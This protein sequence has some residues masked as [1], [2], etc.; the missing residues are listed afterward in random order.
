MEEIKNTQGPSP[1]VGIALI[2]VVLVVVAV[3]FGSK[4]NFDKTPIK[5]LQNVQLVL[6]RKTSDELKSSDDDQDNLPLWLE[7]FY[8]SDPNNADTDGDGTSDGDEVAVK[9]DPTVAGPD[10]PLLTF[11]DNLETSI[12]VSDFKPGTLTESVSVDLFQKY[13]SLKQQGLLSPEDEQKMVE[14]ISQNA[15]QESALKNKYTKADLQIVSSTEESI[16]AYGE[17]YAQIAI[18]I[19]LE[20]DSYKN[21]RD[22]LAYLKKNGEVYQQ[23]ANQILIMSVPDV[24]EDVHVELLNQIINTSSFFE[25][26]SEAEDDPVTA[27][28][29]TVQYQNTQVSERGL[30]TT[31]SNYFKNN[32]IIFDTDSTSNFWKQFEN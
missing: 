17:R 3:I 6:E 16:S 25:K 12:D 18:S 7:E 11:R 32:G 26:I 23:Y 8:R 5:D 20:L 9:R 21:M 10:D 22:D 2:L 31:L 1:K 30:Y 14:Q 15:V 28:I 24:F 4:I 27:L 29:V 19:F 13:L